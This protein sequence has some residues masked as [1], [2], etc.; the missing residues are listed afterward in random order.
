MLKIIQAMNLKVKKLLL[1]LILPVDSLST[2]PLELKL[3]PS[4]DAMCTHRYI[5]LFIYGLPP[6]VDK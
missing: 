2:R 4:G 5:C 3:A 6:P 1:E